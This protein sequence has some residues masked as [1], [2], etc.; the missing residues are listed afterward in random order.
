M[1][2]KAIARPINKAKNQFVK[3]LK[4]NKATD[5]D[6]FEGKPSNEWDYYRMVSGFIGEDL[7][8]VTFMMWIGRVSISYSDESNSYVK[9]S[10]DEFLELID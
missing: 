8:T 5:I 9:L 3:W 2:V 4:D 10:I 7:Y 1:G 6:I